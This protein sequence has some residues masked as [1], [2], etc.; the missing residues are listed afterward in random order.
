MSMAEALARARPV[1][2]TPNDV[3]RVF[4]DDDFGL[5]RAARYARWRRAHD[6]DPAAMERFVRRLATIRALLEAPPRRRIRPG[7]RA[8]GDRPYL[9]ALIRI[10]DRYGRWCPGT[11]PAGARANRAV[12]RRAEQGAGHE[13]RLYRLTARLWRVID[14]AV[15]A[16]RIESPDALQ[17]RC[18]AFRRARGLLG[19]ATTRAWIRANG[20]SIHSFADLVAFDARLALIGDAS[21]TYTLGLP[22]GIEPVCWLHDAI[23]LG[24]FYSGLRRRVATAARTDGRARRPGA[25]DL[26]RALRKHWTRLG[27]PAPLN[28]EDY[29]RSLDFSDGAAELASALHDRAARGGAVPSMKRR[30]PLQRRPAERR[31]R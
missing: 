31:R 2:V 6:L 17:A 15:T 27:E 4:E 25:P 9:L 30:S 5:G 11:I 22:D 19:E 10:D 1:A 23:R 16:L 8:A 18:D 24:G 26:E 21:R 13:F 12:V 14:E 20:L 29:A 7:G 28:L 3:A